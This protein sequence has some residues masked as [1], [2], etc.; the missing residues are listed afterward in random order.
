MAQGLKFT[1]DHCSEE[2]GERDRP[3][4][5]LVVGS[6]DNG[7]MAA[8]I[9]LPP[10]AW[11]VLKRGAVPRMDFCPDCLAKALGQKSITVEEHDELVK[12]AGA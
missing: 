3:V 9:K 4:I 7:E 12:A 6:T 1:C 2:C 11:R 10:I 8:D 5:Y